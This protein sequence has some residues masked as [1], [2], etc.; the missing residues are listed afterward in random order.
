LGEDQLIRNA[1]IL[2]GI[3]GVL[4]HGRYD[5]SS[6]LET[7]WRLHQAWRGSALEII[8]DAGHGGGAMPDRIIEAMQR[9]ALAR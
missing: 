5:I 6:P 1:S 9:V 7:A 8:D 3:P 4:L 2:N